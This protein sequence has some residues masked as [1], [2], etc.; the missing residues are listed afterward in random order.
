M[1]RASNQHP[2]DRVRCHPRGFLY[3]ARP[4]L[5][6]GG[7]DPHCARPRPPPR[8]PCPSSGRVPTPYRVDENIVLGAEATTPCQL[9]KQLLP[10]L[11]FQQDGTAQEGQLCL[12]W[13][14]RKDRRVT[15]LRINTL[16]GRDRRTSGPEAPRAPAQQGRRSQPRPGR[17]ACS[18]P[19]GGTGCPRH[20]VFTPPPKPRGCRALIHMKIRE[21]SGHPGH[22]GFL[23]DPEGVSQGPG[24][25]HPGEEGRSLTHQYPTAPPLVSELL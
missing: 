18:H 14:P 13:V 19:G 4:P 15:S 10:E 7:E 23:P 20:S 1:E 6:A 17:V 2:R 9:P 11:P 12:L 25:R 3:E 22:P 16:P 8:P 21:A 5:G 24:Y